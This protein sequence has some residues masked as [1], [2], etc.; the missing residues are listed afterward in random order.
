MSYVVEDY[1][2]EKKKLRILAISTL[3]IILISMSLAIAF[4][5]VYQGYTYIFFAVISG[6]TGAVLLLVG[7]ERLELSAHKRS[8]NIV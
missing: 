7:A 1:Q 4:Y 2:K 8:D 3:I 5:Y 6:L